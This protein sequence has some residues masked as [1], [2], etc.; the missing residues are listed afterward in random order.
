M[1]FFGTDQL[2]FQRK[3]P[4]PRVANVEGFR[5]ETPVSALFKGIFS[6]P[7]L[8]KRTVHTFYGAAI[9]GAEVNAGVGFM[10]R[11]T[12]RQSYTELLGNKQNFSDGSTEA[13]RFDAP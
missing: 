3:N 8:G 12:T 10:L 5:V 2:S 6:A 1:M 11:G 13:I 9:G 7:F 4:E